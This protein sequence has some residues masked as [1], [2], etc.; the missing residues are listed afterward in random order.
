MTDQLV[1]QGY[2]PPAIVPDQLP[3]SSAPDLMVV[4]TTPLEYVQTW[5]LNA[6]EWRGPLT[7]DQYL[8]R[9]EFLKNQTLTKDDQITAWILTSSSLVPN[10]DGTRPILSACETLLK[11]AYIA[12]GGK[13]NQV[14]AHG[15]ASVYTRPEYRGRG[16]A[17][18]MLN[19][20]GKAL[21]TWQQVDGAKGSFSVLF[22][23]IG[24][25]YYA[26]FGWKTFPSTHIL[27]SPLPVGDVLEVIRADLDVPEVEDLR[28][29]DL[30]SLPTV[31][32]IELELEERSR[33]QPQATFVAI[34]P[35]QE[36][37]QWHHAREEVQCR[38]LGLPEPVIKGAIHRH[39]GT[40]LIWQHLFASKP[41]DCHMVILRTVI[42]PEAKTSKP[43][44]V[45]AA[46]T[47]LLLRAQLE[48]REWEM[49]KG[50]EVWSP[51]AITLR[52]AQALGK[53]IKTPVEV[54]SRDKEHVCCLRW[55]GDRDDGVIWLANERFEWC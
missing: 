47:S 31:S 17:G 6:E 10:P 36:H 11:H 20:L 18:R 16:Y 53:I 51:E 30:A 55:E 44:E 4:P 1:H 14:L 22:S 26:K 5:H 12:R 39:T 24:D 43:K 48:A 52:A 8:D 45:E 46:L 15:I 54:I 49:Q 40:A 32:H 25:Q 29:S 38:I 21:E 35:D 23:D 19:E 2:L 50:V 34:R 28:A 37:F 13:M 3:T 7:M 42:A 9:E 41:E 27:L 33:N